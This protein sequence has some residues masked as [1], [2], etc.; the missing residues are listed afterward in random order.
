MNLCGQIFGFIPVI[1]HALI[2]LLLNSLY[3]VVAETLTEFENHRTE[4]EHENSIIIKR[5]LFEAFDCYIALFYI[6]FYELDPIALRQELIGLYM[7]DSLRRVVCEC[8]IP[9]TMQKF[10][11]YFRERKDKAKE[12]KYKKSDGDDGDGGNTDNG[13]GGDESTEVVDELLDEYEQFDDYLEMVIEYG[14]ITLFASAFPLAPILSMI[15]NLVELR[16][17]MFKLVYVC[18]R[19]HVNRV[20]NIGIWRNIMYVLFTLS[21]ASNCFLF[22]FTTE[23]MMVWVPSWF[24]LEK[25]VRWDGAIIEEQELAKGK[26]RY[27]VF[28]VF[29]LE[30]LLL[31][32]CGLILAAIPS[33][34]GWVR[35]DSAK[36]EY[37]REVALRKLLRAH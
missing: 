16:S 25:E 9:L 15:C 17:D 18:R 37:Q 23:Q 13:W 36:R 33:Q 4:H 11:E 35:I 8:V 3:R 27:V 1:L 22:G 5:F 2:I 10:R 32:C 28:M 20:R 7:V 34:P 12:A 31:L 6:A 19:P 30:H 14:Y 29:A 24:E 21:I 26:G